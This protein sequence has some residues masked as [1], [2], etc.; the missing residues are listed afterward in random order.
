MEDAHI[1]N[2][3][4]DAGVG[5]FAVFDGHGGVECAKFCEK[6]FGDKLR[7]QAE[8]ASRKDFGRALE[9]TFLGM[10]KMLMTPKGMEIMVTISK[11]YPNQTSPIERAL[12]FHADSKQ[13]RFI[14]IFYY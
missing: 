4:I 7:E 3:Q 1:V 8:Y 12:R 11:E 2:P 13:T 14:P 10:D 9:N 5:L 6:F